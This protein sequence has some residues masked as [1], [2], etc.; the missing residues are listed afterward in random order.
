ML[1]RWPAAWR[2][3]AD[4]PWVLESRARRPAAGLEDERGS[5]VVA[6]EHAGL[7]GQPPAWRTS[8]DPTWWWRSRARQMGGAME[9][10]RGGGVARWCVQPGG[11]EKQYGC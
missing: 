5:S 9:D 8:A 1:A 3:S 7:I 2:M 6:E 4:L 10:E 11:E